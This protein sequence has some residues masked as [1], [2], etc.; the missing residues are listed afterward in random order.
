[1]D[2]LTVRNLKRAPGRK[3]FPLAL[4]A[5]SVAVAV[6]WPG[7]RFLVLQPSNQRTWE[8][9]ME[10]L[11]HIV[12]DGNTV[13]IHSER[14]FHWTTDGPLSSDYVDRSYDVDRL[15]RVW[16]VQEP[17][18][19]E[20]FDGFTGVAHTY[21]VFDFEDQPPVAV[22]VEARRERGERY[23][24]VRG[25]L[26]DFELIYIWGTEQDVTGRRAVLERNQLYMYPLVGSADSARRLFL[27]LAR[28]S[29]QL[30]TQPRFYNS[31][32]SNC[33][34]ELAKVANRAEPGMVPPNIALIFPGY[35]DSVL[36]D[37]GRIPNDAPLPSI[38]Q[39]YA[40]TDTV[41]ATLYEPDFSNLLRAR[42][43]TNAD[44]GIANSWK[45]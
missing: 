8:Y 45:T 40:I 13:D 22:S 31:F 33:T 9:G 3:W 34:N 4:F 20:P 15:Q 24:A 21:L 17:F 25:T 6:A 28:T 29:Q 10:T 35:A 36:Y 27:E 16:F 26:N 5:A 1:L 39:R 11:P 42:L 32:A 19:I 18:T 2:V 44:A 38:R 41:A 30:E 7:Y 12:V 43:E 23:D 37:L 14:D